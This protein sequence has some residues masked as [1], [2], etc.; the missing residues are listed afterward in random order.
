MLQ[1]LTSLLKSRV[2][3]FALGA[4]ACAIANQAISHIRSSS[5]SAIIESA[6][7][8]A[9]IAIVQNVSSNAM[10]ARIKSLSSLYGEVKR[11]QKVAPSIKPIETIVVDMTSKAPNAGRP[12]IVQDGDD[13]KLHVDGSIL[14]SDGVMAFVGSAK[15]TAGKDDVVL[16]DKPIRAGD[17][18]IDR[19][20][21][22][23][24]KNSWSVG[25][26]V[27]MIGPGVAY[28]ATVETPSI[29]VFGLGISANAGFMLGD[30]PA[31][32]VGVRFSM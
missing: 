27:G 19:T 30:R 25:P 31:H 2:S 15:V 24:M 9:N 32:W 20:E 11:A 10:S 7:A 18:K 12:C 13:V 17:A 8:S 21:N 3:F 26:V 6:L 4:V 22:H 28:G 14:K 29:N 23:V 1:A 16:L 5:K